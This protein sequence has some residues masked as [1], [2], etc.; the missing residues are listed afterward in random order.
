MS[1]I[2]FTIKKEELKV[3]MERV[4]DAPRELVWKVLTD[5][6]MVPKWWG[7]AKYETKVEKMDFR[8]GGEWRF[9]H[10]GEGQE[11]AFYGVYKKIEPP[12]II[13]DTFNFE[14]IGPGHEMV[15][16]MALEDIGNNQTKATQ[17]SVYNNIEDL[18]GMVGSGMES[19]AVETWERLAQ[20]VEKR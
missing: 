3:V 9:V 18:E 2:S 4:F 11:Y 1:K 15:E 17:T 14:P 16:T 10:K 19:G 12:H 13:S 6:Q 20:I 8:V 7:P 5:P